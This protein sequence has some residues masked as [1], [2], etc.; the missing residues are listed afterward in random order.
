MAVIWPIGQVRARQ[1]AYPYIVTVPNVNVIIPLPLIKQHL[2]L[3]LLYEGED[4]YLTMLATSAAEYAQKYTRRVFL[5]TTFL[6]YRDNFNFI[7]TTLR[8]APFQALLTYQWTVD[9]VVWI[10][11]DP[12]SY[13]VDSQPHDA[14]SSIYIK[15][16]WSWPWPPYWRF[17]SVRATFTAGFGDTNTSIPNQLMLGMLNHIAAMYYDRG[18]SQNGDPSSWI[19]VQTK[20]AYDAFKIIDITGN[21][22]SWNYG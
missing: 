2:R 17:Q 21:D 18:D 22:Y 19:P 3:D 11:V 14:Y 4:Q 10:D 6:T 8:R 15:Q 12:L 5:T 9:G 13:Y 16:G 1:K 20:V 7:S